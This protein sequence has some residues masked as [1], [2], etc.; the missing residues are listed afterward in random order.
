MAA[1]AQHTQQKAAAPPDLQEAV[2]MSWHI[3]GPAD[4]V[5]VSGQTF[6]RLPGEGTPNC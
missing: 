1:S 6:T 3:D 4:S 2:E 5:T